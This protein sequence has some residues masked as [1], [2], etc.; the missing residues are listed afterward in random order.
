MTYTYDERDRRVTRTDA[1][2]QVER[3]T[4]DKMDRVKTYTDGPAQPGDHLYL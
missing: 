4:Y 3:W 1:L 2:G